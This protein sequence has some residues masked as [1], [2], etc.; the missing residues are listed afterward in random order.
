VENSAR[1]AWSAAV[2]VSGARV[3]IVP[4][5]VDD[6]GAEGA[7]SGFFGLDSRFFGRGLA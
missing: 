7:I 6:G 2:S 4:L 1:N 5:W 3:L